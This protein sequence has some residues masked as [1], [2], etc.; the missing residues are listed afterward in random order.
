MSLFRLPEDDERHDKAVEAAVAAR[1][2][3]RMG[4]AAEAEAVLAAYL[5]SLAEQGARFVEVSEVAK[6]LREDVHPKSYSATVAEMFLRR[7]G[8]GDER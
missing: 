7:F 4:Y 5:A 2:V 3:A 1:R 6:W 8:G